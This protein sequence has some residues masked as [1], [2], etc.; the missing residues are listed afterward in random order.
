[1]N[2][3]VQYHRLPRWAREKQ[4]RDRPLMPGNPVDAFQRL[5]YTGLVVL[6]L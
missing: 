2:S 3:E 5:T 6:L 4:K 1:M